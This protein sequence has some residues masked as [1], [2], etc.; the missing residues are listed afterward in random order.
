M[1]LLLAGG[2]TVSWLNL[3]LLAGVT[4]PLGVTRSN[5]NQLWNMAG[6]TV[7]VAAASA[8]TRFC[9]WLAPPARQASKIADAAGAPAIALRMNILRISL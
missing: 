4:T 3:T 5:R 6:L 7:Q 1:V 2:L 8:G 9:A